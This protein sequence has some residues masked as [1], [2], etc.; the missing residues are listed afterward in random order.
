[1]RLNA[2]LWH[3]QTSSCAKSGQT[4]ARLSTAPQPICYSYPQ[5]VSNGFCPN[6]F[7]PKTVRD[8]FHS[9]VRFLRGGDK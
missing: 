9:P 2:L 3:C 1:M 5:L 7:L 4:L 6:S 8:E